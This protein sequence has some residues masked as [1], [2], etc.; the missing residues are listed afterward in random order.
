MTLLPYHEHNKKKNH[1][2]PTDLFSV[3]IAIVTLAPLTNLYLRVPALGE[4]FEEGRSFD[5]RL[6]HINTTPTA[7]PRDRGESDS[8]VLPAEYCRC[9]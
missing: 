5:Q 4:G 8:V 1:E 6:N 7:I 3:A 2:N 9:C